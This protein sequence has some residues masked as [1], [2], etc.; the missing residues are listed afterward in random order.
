MIQMLKSI[1]RFIR[2]ILKFFLREDPI[3]N[4]ADVVIPD[5]CTIF[6]IE[7][8]SIGA[9]TKLGINNIIFATEAPLKI[10]KY[11]MF[12][13][14]VCIFTGNHRTD[15]VGEYMINVTA[16]MKLPENDQPVII[17]DDVWIATGAI[18]LKGVRIGRGSVISAGSVV[19][20]DVPPYTIYFSAEN[21]K[22][23]FTPRQIEEHERLMRE[24]YGDDFYEEIL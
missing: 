12:S 6:G 17:E 4:R 13:P 23:R 20:K 8:I 22:P 11:V 16:D 7:N 2:T 24:K 5:E 21:Q 18:I 1:R 19:Y 3:Q 15:L 10:G 9:N 14:N